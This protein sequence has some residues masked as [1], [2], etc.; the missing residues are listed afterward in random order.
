M[1]VEKRKE[2][3]NILKTVFDPEL[4]INI[5]DLGLVYGVDVDKEYNV[6]LIVTF[7]S[8]ACP[9]ADTLLSEIKEK[10]ES[11]DWIKEYSVEVT[12]DPPWNT[13][14][15]SEEALLSAGLL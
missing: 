12:F 6:H 15:M 9:F 2:I 8:P 3:I 7:T 1:L 13:N 11:L 10:I 4:N 5:Y 14:M